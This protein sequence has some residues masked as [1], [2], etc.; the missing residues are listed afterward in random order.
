MER[1]GLLQQVTQ[2]EDAKRLAIIAATF[3]PA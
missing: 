1:D 3:G 2:E